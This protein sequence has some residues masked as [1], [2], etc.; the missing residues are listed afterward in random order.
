MGVLFA[1]N[2]TSTSALDPSLWELH[3]DDHSHFEGFRF[4]MY[5][6]LAF[7]ITENMHQVSAA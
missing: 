7:T 4:Y 1:P 6:F 2:G 3:H 5:L